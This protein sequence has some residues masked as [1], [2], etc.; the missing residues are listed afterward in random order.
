MMY[1]IETD[2]YQLVYKT[3]MEVTDG[4]A[5]VASAFAKTPERF[6]MVYF[7]MIDYST[8]DHYRTTDHIDNISDA[9]F[10]LNVYS[11]SEQGRKSECKR[12]AMAV[13]E[14][15][16]A[17]GMSRISM[18]SNP[19]LHDATVYRLTARYRVRVGRDGKL[20]YR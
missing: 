3:V 8:S 13:D 9:T 1:D 15:L 6:P 2:I 16:S 5:D 18:T 14:K 17:I 20:Y 19:D 11:N 12:I 10:D 7:T 4:K